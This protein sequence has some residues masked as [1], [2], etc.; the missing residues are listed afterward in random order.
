MLRSGP[1]ILEGVGSTGGERAS[2]AQEFDLESNRASGVSSSK[3]VRVQGMDVPLDGQGP[4]GCNQTLGKHLAPENPIAGNLEGGALE[5]GGFELGESE[6]LRAQ[7][8]RRPPPT[9]R[10]VASFSPL[11]EPPQRLPACDTRVR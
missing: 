6:G 5:H 11:P 9:D 2:V 4:P 3:K 8:R 10:P 7:R 1:S